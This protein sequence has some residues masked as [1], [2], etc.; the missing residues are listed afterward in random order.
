MEIELKK[1]EEE[2]KLKME[3]EMKNNTSSNEE[4]VALQCQLKE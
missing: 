3:E 2:I 1:W 4:L